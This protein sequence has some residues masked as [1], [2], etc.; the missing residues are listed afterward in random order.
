M[1]VAIT[2]SSG[3][4]GTAL[5]AALRADGHDVIRLVRAAPTAA[6]AIAW[7]PRADRGGRNPG[8]H[9][10]LGRRALPQ[11]GGTGPAAAAVP[12]GPRRAYRD[13]PAGDE[14][15]RAVGVGDGRAVRPR[16]RRPQ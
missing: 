1:K 12:A 15:D 2:G 16:P 11:R 5:V 6:D 4:I 13:R 9:A 14:L 8:G 3:L 7:D 10:A